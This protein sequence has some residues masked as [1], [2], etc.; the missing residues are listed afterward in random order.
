MTTQG[1]P[2][3]TPPSRTPVPRGQWAFPIG[4][5]APALRAVFNQDTVVE[6]HKHGKETCLALQSGGKT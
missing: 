4:G 3:Q 5:C 2:S 6:P 1:G